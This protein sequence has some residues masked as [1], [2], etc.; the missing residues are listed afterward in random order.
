M[1]GARAQWI[2]R[3]CCLIIL[4]AL[5]VIPA[6]LGQNIVPATDEEVN[7]SPLLK[8]FDWK[9][10]CQLYPDLPINGVNTE[11]LTRKHYLEFGVPE[12]RLFPKLLPEEP[13]YS[14]ALEKLANFVKFLDEASVPMQDRTFLIFHI[15]KFD[16]KNSKEVILNNLKIF[17]SAMALD[18]QGLSGIFYWF[19]IVDGHDNMLF[20]SVH[21]DAFNT[22][23]SIWAATPSDIY[24]HLRTLSI[25]SQRLIKS[26][27]SVFFL[28]NGVRGPL[29]HREKGQWIQ[30]FRSLLFSPRTN[31]A[32][33]GATMS[34]E[35]APHV[36]THFF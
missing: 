29:L 12:G 8:D 6:V 19:N 17:Q 27:G 18:N 2:S 11:F 13:Y 14:K 1:A 30:P 3:L 34:C 35:V 5:A 24:T 10:Y 15:G 7:N 32:M 23:L 25:L 16:S 22:A 36:Q 31:N 20:Q 9:A 26:F 21:A 33:V 28:N 4:A